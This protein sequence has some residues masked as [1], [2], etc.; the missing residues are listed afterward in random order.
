MPRGLARSA[1][2]RLSREARSHNEK[3]KKRRLI[4]KSRL[5]C[6]KRGSHEAGR[7]RGNTK[8]WERTSKLTEDSGKAQRNATQKNVREVLQEP[9]ESETKKKLYYI[10]E[11]REHD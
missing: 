7:I 4:A 2:R 10:N 6:Q 1:G 9:P 5:R 3:N 8:L 11:W